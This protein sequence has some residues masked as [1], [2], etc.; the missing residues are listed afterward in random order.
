MEY[1]SLLQTPYAIYLVSFFISIPYLHEL[2]QKFR[3]CRRCTDHGDTLSR[4]HVVLLPV[5]SIN[6]RNGL[7]QFAR[8]NHNFR[9]CVVLLCLQFLDLFKLLTSCSW[10]RRWI[11]TRGLTAILY[12]LGC[13]PP[14]NIHNG[15]SR[16]M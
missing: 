1:R 10:L 3:N 16:N 8:Q 4:Y 7:L 2:I 12:C 15:E 14:H 13:Q 11:T 9:H 5:G 6:S